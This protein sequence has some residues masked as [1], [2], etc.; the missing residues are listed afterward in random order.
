MPT[1]DPGQAY[2]FAD[3]LPALRALQEAE[4]V[5]WDA[6]YR[7]WLITRYDD[8]RAGLADPRLSTIRAMPDADEIG[9]AH[10]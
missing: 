2:R 9:R 10:V 1:F 4:P 7:A 8:V 5:H 6:R 3:P